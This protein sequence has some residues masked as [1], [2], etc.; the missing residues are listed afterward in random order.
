[1][2]VILKNRDGKIVGKVYRL[3]SG[4]FIALD[5]RTFKSSTHDNFESAKGWLEHES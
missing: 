3:F 5:L 2:M 1:M 4:K